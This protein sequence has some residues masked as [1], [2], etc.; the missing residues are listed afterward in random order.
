MNNVEDMEKNLKTR[1]LFSTF[2]SAVPFRM[3]LLWQMHATWISATTQMIYAVNILS[4]NTKSKSGKP[5]IEILTLKRVDT[6]FR[7]H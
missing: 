6:T 7:P 1:N 4:K 2:N 3:D 5:R